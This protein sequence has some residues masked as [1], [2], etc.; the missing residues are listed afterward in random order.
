LFPS[1]SGTHGP[2]R[3]PVPR[4]AGH[5][6]G[7]GYRLARL[8]IAILDERGLDLRPLPEPDAEPAVAEAVPPRTCVL[9]C[10]EA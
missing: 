6:G 2:E 4:D 9:A 7:Q 8:L 10:G 3:S 5:G 1:P